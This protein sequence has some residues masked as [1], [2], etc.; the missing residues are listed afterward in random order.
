MT[1]SL[2]DIIPYLSGQDINDEGEQEDPAE[3]IEKLNFA[4]DVQIYI[5]ED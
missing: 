5:N 1:I 2:K 3:Y 4:I